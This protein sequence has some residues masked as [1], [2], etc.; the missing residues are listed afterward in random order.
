V[1]TGASQPPSPEVHP[2]T[3]L[4][5]EILDLTEL[6]ESHLQEH[7]TVNPTDLDAMQALIMNG[8]MSPSELAKKLGLTTAAVTTVVDRL[9]ALGHATRTPNSADRRGVVVVPSPA[10]VD[11]AMGA[12][13][14]AIMGIDRAIQG[15]TEQEQATITAYL[16]R[17]ADAYRDQLPL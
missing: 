3:R 15:F 10:S 13:M 9:T 5:R 17:V 1:Q 6:F 16:Q 11:K 7:L 14:P 12:I 2:A 8:P 4:I